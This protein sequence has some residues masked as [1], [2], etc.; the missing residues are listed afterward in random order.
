MELGREK[1]ENTAFFTRSPSPG[2]FED[3][4]TQPRVLKFKMLWGFL[5]CLLTGRCPCGV[6]NAALPEGGHTTVVAEAPCREE[7]NSVWPGAR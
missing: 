2:P 5:K 1:Q 6:W 7:E 3:P 4:G